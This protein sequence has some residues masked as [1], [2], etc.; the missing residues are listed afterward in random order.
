MTVVGLVGRIGAGK[1]T[2]AGMLA[3][4]GATVIDA[5][6]LA[7]EVLDEP[8]VARAIGALFGAEVLDAAGRVHRSAVAALVF[9]AGGECEANLR[10]LEGIVHPRV[11]QRISAALADGRGR[12]ETRGGVVV[13]DVPLLVQ[14]GWTDLCD[15]IV[16]VDCEDRVRRERLAA[17]GWSEPQIAAR[18]AA[19]DRGYRRPA[20]GPRTL[21]VDASGAAAYTRLQ[22]DRIWSDVRR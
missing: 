18:D 6:S 15:W 14:A 21:S 13:L 22:V 20:A 9:G 7:H 3:D 12:E 4:R 17:R 11:R 16:V 8:A 2:V 5:D 19:W 10:A 1:S